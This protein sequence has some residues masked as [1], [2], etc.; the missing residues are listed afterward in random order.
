MWSSGIEDWAKVYDM[1]LKTWL[2]AMKKAEGSMKL[3]SLPFE[4]SV[5]MKESWDTGR[6]W[7]NYAARKSWAFDTIFWKYLDESFFGKREGD[8]SKDDLWKTRVHFLSE[9]E[10]T[11]MAPFVEAKMEKSKER[12]M[13][14]WDPEEA[15][16]HL[17]EVLFD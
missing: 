14:D 15:K 11:A 16:E 1:R 8:F 5:Y 3:Q 12:I 7:L 17:A 6:F 10:R 9:E 4:L 13:V 2:S